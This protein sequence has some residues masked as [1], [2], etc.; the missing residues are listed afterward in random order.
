MLTLPRVIGHRGACAHAP[1][2]TLASFAKAADLGCAMVEFDVRLSADG[3]P[4]VFHDDRLERCSVGRGA[5]GN[6]T[7]A[8]LSPL[9]IPTLAEVLALCAARGLAVDVEIKPDRGMGA[10]T[11]AA[12]LAV[13]RDVWRGPPPLLSSFDHDALAALR[14]LAPDWPRALLV[15]RVPADWPR[16]VR[17]FDCVALGAHHRALPTL[18]VGQLRAAGLAVL[19]FTVNRPGR[20]KRLWA[21]GIDAVFCDAPDRV[22]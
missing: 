21:R 1:E 18:L 2:N 5:V 17:R 19:A 7:L 16:L 11:A 15:E 12:A 22:L 6:H 13:L 20:A 4:V 9:N 8:Q 3:M 14:D 10:A